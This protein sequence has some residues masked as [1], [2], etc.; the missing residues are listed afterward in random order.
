M[1]IIGRHILEYDTRSTVPEYG[2][3]CY[4][5]QVRNIRKQGLRICM[6]AQI[7]PDL[8]QYIL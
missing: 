1:P 3:M 8:L 4:L 5:S 2:E 7:Y 6:G